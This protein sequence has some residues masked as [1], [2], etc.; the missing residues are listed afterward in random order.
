MHLRR[1]CIPLLG[2]KFLIYLLGSLGLYCCSSQLLFFYKLIFCL[3]ILPFITS[4]YTCLL[5]QLCCCQFL[6]LD[7]SVYVL[8]FRCSDVGCVYICNCLIFLLN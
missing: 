7:L 4:R 3:D 5:L 2:G 8:I 6:P 1:M